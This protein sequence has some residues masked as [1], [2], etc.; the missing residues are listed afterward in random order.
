VGRSVGRAVATLALLAVSGMVTGCSQGTARIERASA[1][2][3]PSAAASST[4]ASH[5]H[6]PASGST[7]THDGNRYAVA[8]PGP[9]RPPL[10]TADVLV[11]STRT[12][13]ASVRHRVEALHGV[14]TAMPM[15]F[16]AL[17]VNGRTLSIAAADPAEFRR[18][19]PVQSAQTDAVWSRVAGGE[20]AVDPSLPRKVEDRSGYLR[21]GTVE[22]APEVHV[23]AFA[24]LVKQISAVV[25]DKR[26]EQLGMPRDNALLISTGELTPSAIS[27]KLRRSIGPDATMQILALEF[28]HPVQTAVLSTRSVTSRVGT[29]NYTPHPDGTVSPDPR[30]VR[31]YI[32]TETVPIIGRVTCNKGMIPQLRSALVE[33]VQRR[34]ADKI[35]P[36]QYG[37]CYVP[38]YIANDPAK[39]LSLH[40]WGI[41]VDLNVPE[42]QRGTAGQMDRTVVSIFKKWGFAWGGDWNYTDP[43]HFEMNRVV[44]VH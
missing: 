28:R 13:P 10:R 14:V 38:R 30:W 33:I 24:P 36:G 43:M 11:T 31:R 3:Q 42:N 27:G 26:G 37:G 25:N 16:A 5:S 8:D 7:A 21:L 2:R 44:D 12:I 9:F 35:H 1:S 39:G 20:I 17:S 40:T 22:D 41:A 34:L 18:F 29:F 6:A 23:G 4:G 15:S 19:T 32:R